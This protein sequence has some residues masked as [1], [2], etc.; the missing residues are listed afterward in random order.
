MVLLRWV[1]PLALVAAGVVFFTLG[2]E[3]NN[4]F[5]VMFVGIALVVAIFVGAIALARRSTDDR[6]AEEAAREAFARTGRWPHDPE[7]DG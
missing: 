6:E 1:L 3:Q 5:G 2:G 4:A 7:A